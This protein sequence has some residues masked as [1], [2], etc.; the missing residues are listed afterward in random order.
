MRATDEARSI[1]A[2]PSS[3]GTAPLLAVEDVHVALDGQP[4]LAGVD[5]ELHAGELLGL[6]GPNGAGKTTLL[7]AATALVPL[8]G[9]RIAIHGRSVLD[10]GRREL[11][12]SVAVVQQLPEAPA[13]MLVAELVLLGRNPHLGL[14]GRESAHDYAVAQDAMR[15]AGC[16]RFA[17][18]PLGTL[19][20]GE[21][22]RAF[23]AR[24][25]A[26]QPALLLLDEPTANLDPEAQGETFE[27]LRELAA[28]GV[29]V[30]AV[31]HDLTLAAAYCDRIALLHTGR[32]VASGAP[33]EAL[34]AQTVAR[35]YGSR[36]TVMPHPR[37]GAPMVVPAVLEGPH[38]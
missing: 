7:R 24:S 27:L 34:T 13:T 36:V 35:V 14:L 19:S 2:R 3:N 32:I 22:R 26:Q 23:I 8:A 31:V 11:A 17:E 9:G 4:V 18:R 1:D 20:G 29:G 12:R 25:L 21:R 16:E 10:T 15:R 5:L 33:K 6:V 28:G 38:D 37:S 30:L